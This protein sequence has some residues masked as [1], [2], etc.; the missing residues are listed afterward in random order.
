MK[1]IGTAHPKSGKQLV[2]GPMMFSGGHVKRAVF[3]MYPGDDENDW[4]DIGY[5]VHA[6]GLF[7]GLARWVPDG[8]LAVLMGYQPFS[9]DSPTLDIRDGC[10][11]LWELLKHVLDDGEGDEHA[12][13]AVS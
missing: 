1:N 4:Q 3:M 9:V 2:L 6:P 8:A 5:L 7:Y 11:Q 13:E 10:D 12:S